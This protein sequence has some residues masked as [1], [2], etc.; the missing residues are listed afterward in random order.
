MNPNR[1]NLKRALRLSLGMAGWL[2]L[3]GQ[4]V[5]AEN[6]VLHLRNGDRIAGTIVAED[7]NRVVLATSWIQ[8]L[9]VPL[10]AIQCRESV[11]NTVMPTMV[12]KPAAL[13]TE[14]AATNIVV[15]ANAAPPS[16]TTPSEPKP[17][18]PKRW[19]TSLS[20]GTDMQFGAH[21]R[22]LYYARLKLM[23][24]QPYKSDP[25]KFFRN[26]FD[27]AA[28]YGETD[29]LKSAD[30]IYGSAKTDL[31]VSRRVFVYNL[32]GAG[33][34]ELRKIDLEYEVG[35]GVGCH[36]FTRPK[37]VMNVE[38]GANYQGQERSSSPDVQNFYFRVAEDVAWKITPHMTLVE[39]AE[40]FPRVENPGEFRARLDATLSFALWQNL[41]L[42]LS[43]LDLY[44]T[45][46]ALGA[47][48]NEMQIRS[49]LGITY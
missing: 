32:T 38:S 40:I 14:P 8:E 36:L 31:D 41:S 33:Y 3:G 25:K 24:E 6:T 26:L 13:A 29:G 22:E 1:P 37:F 7:T 47:D 20:L 15:V 18:T 11:T 43:L 12:A 44:D 35:P 34:D 27:V 21:D 4:L 23:Y 49:T 2:A 39:K 19:K 10:S 42:N 16:A 28:D 45:N 48:N 5:R 9:P 30:R 46:P 17:P